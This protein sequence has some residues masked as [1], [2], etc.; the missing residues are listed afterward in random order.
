MIKYEVRTEHRVISP[1]T[2]P[3]AMPQTIREKIE[4]VEIGSPEGEIAASF[5][6]IVLADR[7][8]ELLNKEGAS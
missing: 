6:D 7:V 4:L 3:G 2:V 8:C 1:P 5:N